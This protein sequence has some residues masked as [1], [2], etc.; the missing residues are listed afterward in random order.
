V[1][2]KFADFSFREAIK[3]VKTFCLLLQIQG[4]QETLLTG[5]RLL[6]DAELLQDPC[7]VQQ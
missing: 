1:F 7:L 6:L 2:V 4:L 3:T 5:L